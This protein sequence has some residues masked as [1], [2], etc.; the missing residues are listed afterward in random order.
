[1][2]ELKM[3][4]MSDVKR[5][6]IPYLWEPYIALGSLSLILGNGGTGKSWFSLAIASAVTKGEA[7]PGSDTA[8]PPSHVIVQN[9]EN[10]IETVISH[11][12]DTLHADCSKIHSI[13][14]SE[15]PLSLTDERIEA[16]IKQYGAKLF[17]CDPLQ[18]HLSSNISMN[19]AESIRPAF[20]RLSKVAER[21]NCAILLVGHLN[22]SRTVSQYKG[23][24]SVDI[25]NA[26]PSVLFLGIT[27]SVA[28]IRAAVHGKS[29][30]AEQGVSRSF[31]LSRENGFEWLG[32]CDATINDIIAGDSGRR[33]SKLEIASEFLRDVLAEEAIASVDLSALAGE[34]GIKAATLKRAKGVIGV[35][36][37]KVNGRWKTS[38]N[39]DGQEAQKAP[40]SSYD[41]LLEKPA[42]A[43]F[44]GLKK[45][46]KL[47]LRDTLK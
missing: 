22:K 45:A 2:P 32:A 11:R 44:L 34:Y 31:R 29:N 21:T 13:D 9:T 16:A 39:K 20:T 3:I 27:D 1:M 12:L 19:R 18:A 30:F 42:T 15:E 28:G 6:K 24:G 10:D 33:M 4:T 8:L 26:V 17:I 38:L 41:E 40:R 14:V 7:L 47:K 43:R 36:A 46:K 37:K 23:L 25:L 35:E 5:R